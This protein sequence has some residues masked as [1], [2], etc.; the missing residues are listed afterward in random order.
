MGLLDGKVAVITGAA[1][2]IGRAQASLFVEEG[3]KVVLA[4]LNENGAKTLAQE[5]SP[6]GEKALAIK[7][8]VLDSSDTEN[9][10]NKVIDKFGKIDILSNT[11]GAFDE[12]APLLETSED[13][14]DKVM[15]MNTK[16][17]YFVTKAVLP[18][19]IKNESGSVINIASGAGLKGGGGGISYTTSK[20]GVIGFA[21]QVASDYKSKGIR[22]NAIA[23]GLIETPMIEE[24]LKDKPE[25]YDGV[26]GASGRL[27]QAEDIAKAALFLASDQSDYVNGSTIPVDGGLTYT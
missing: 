21:R 25:Y 20:H 19:M 1:S 23:P 6:D 26:V 11:A 5:L 15:N 10:V 27:G 22:S 7:V 8:N 2:G 12:L 4:D 24:L 13:L 3:A 16:S 17:L 14:W 9:M 18:E